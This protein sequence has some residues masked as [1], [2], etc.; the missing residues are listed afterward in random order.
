M[1]FTR[2]FLPNYL[3]SYSVIFLFFLNL[4]RM[5]LFV[6]VFWIFKRFFLSNAHLLCCMEAQE[7]FY[8]TLGN[9][10]NLTSATLRHITEYRL[11]MIY[12]TSDG[13]H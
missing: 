3:Q 7:S 2:F 11:V 6:N 5:I 8:R 10:G 4:P 12:D 1:R 9:S 13:A